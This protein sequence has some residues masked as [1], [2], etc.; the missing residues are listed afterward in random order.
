MSGI[1][2]IPVVVLKTE[3][4]PSRILAELFN[5]Y[6]KESCF[7][8]C[9]KV[10]LVVPVFKNVGKR[11]TAKNYCPVNLSVVNKVFEV[12]GYYS[13]RYPNSEHCVRYSPKV[14]LNQN[15]NFKDKVKEI[16]S[17]QFKLL[18]KRCT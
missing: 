8:N 7:T 13:Y 3:H 6:L 11:S 2:F 5:M 12:F 16:L 10:S 18:F 4:E 15:A 17:F 9:W 14:I 1:D